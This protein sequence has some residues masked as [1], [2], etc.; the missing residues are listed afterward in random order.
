MTPI[1]FEKLEA[2]GKIVK[3]ALTHGSV[4][5]IDIRFKNI[6]ALIMHDSYTNG[7]YVLA[8]CEMPSE[9]A[10]VLLRGVH[11]F[12]ENLSQHYLFAPRPNEVLLLHGVTY[13]N[14]PVRDFL[15]KVPRK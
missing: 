11:E 4:V 14:V 13:L 10:E 15:F 3:V 9:Q 12:K 8:Q 6:Y 2:K 5:S 1:F 7:R